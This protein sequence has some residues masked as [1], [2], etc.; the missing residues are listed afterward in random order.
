MN[1]VIG[2]ET[3]GCVLAI[4]T[5]HLLPDSGLLDVSELDYRIAVGVR[6]EGHGIKPDETVLLQRD[7]L[8]SGR[9]RALE[10]AID[11]L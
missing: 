1:G 2:T 11:K 4:R 10:R 9:D 5:R 3:C 7:D 8:Y 6:L